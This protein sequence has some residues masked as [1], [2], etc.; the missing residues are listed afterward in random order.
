MNIVAFDPGVTTGCVV[1][2]YESGSTFL[3]TR[4]EEI[5][6]GGRF[7]GIKRILNFYNPEFIVVESF[8]LYPHKAQ[9]QIGQDFPSAQVIGIIE[10]YAYEAGLLDRIRKQPAAARVKTKVLDTHKAA[11]RSTPHIID[12]YQHLRYFIVVK[13]PKE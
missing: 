3:I 13:L 6:W 11:L 1:A 12:A 4:A 7:H 9:A 8:R 5:P 10:A 2:A